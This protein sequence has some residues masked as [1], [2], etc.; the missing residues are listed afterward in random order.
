ML[1]PAHLSIPQRRLF[2][3]RAIMAISAAVVFDAALIYAVAN[4]LTFHGLR[5]IPH[6][7]QVEVLKS[8]PP[9]APPVVVPQTQLVKPSVASV[10]PPE[11]QIQPQQPPQITVAKMP[12]HPVM[13]PPVQTAAAPAPPKP[14]GITA[15]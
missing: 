4:G 2:S 7:V 6:A 8:P 13:P 10:P 1:R 11:I 12:P 15:P 5:V 14:Q 3:P 9:K